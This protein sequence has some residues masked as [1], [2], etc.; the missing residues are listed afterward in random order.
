MTMQF[1]VFIFMFSRAPFNIFG[2]A[3]VLQ[4]EAESIGSDLLLRS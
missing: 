3:I 2:P 1:V 4:S